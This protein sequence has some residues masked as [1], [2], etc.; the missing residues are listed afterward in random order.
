MRAVADRG[1]CCAYGV[2]HEICP[3]VWTLDDAGIVAIADGATIPAALLDKAIEGAQAC[4]ANA[5]SVEPAA[6]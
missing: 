4:P 5:L 3:E 2:C 6:A 1:A